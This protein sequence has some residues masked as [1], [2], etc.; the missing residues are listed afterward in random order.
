MDYMPK[1]AGAIACLY[2]ANLLTH[3]IKYI[4]SLNW[5]TPY[6]IG[7]GLFIGSI[8]ALGLGTNWL[9]DSITQLSPHAL[10]SRTVQVYGAIAVIGLM[11]AL[12]TP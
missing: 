11:L 3:L 7:L 2:G 9:E 6:Q 8:I 1:I 12:L 5:F 4:F 10:H